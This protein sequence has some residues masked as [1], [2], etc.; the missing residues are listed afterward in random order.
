MVKLILVVIF[1]AGCYLLGKAH[2]ETKIITKQVEVIKYVE[3][4]RAK[5]QAIPN[6][7]RASLLKLMYNEK[8]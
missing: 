8:L 2:T 3:Q 4:Q 5:I 6:A 7:D 1:G